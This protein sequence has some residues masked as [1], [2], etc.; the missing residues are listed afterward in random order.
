M[1]V[2]NWII[3]ILIGL[4]I[5]SYVGLVFTVVHNTFMLEKIF[6]ILVQKEEESD[7]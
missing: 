1:T 7:E 6:K 3:V 4:A 5:G 2:Y